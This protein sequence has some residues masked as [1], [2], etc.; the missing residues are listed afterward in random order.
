MFPYIC[1]LKYNIQWSAVT[2]LSNYIRHCNKSGRKW[3]RY[4]NY[5]RHPWWASCGATIVRIWEKTDRVTMALHYITILLCS[6]IT[7]CEFN[8]ILW[9]NIFRP[10][11][12]YLMK[13]T[14]LKSPASLNPWL[15]QQLSCQLPDLLMCVW[16]RPGMSGEGK[17]R[18]EWRLTGGLESLFIHLLT[19]VKFLWMEQEGWT[20]FNMNNCFLQIPRASWW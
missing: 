9:F 4:S 11:L 5:N 15:S 3:I 8:V 13:Y 18:L 20:Q 10:K 17:G 14:D 6:R 16:A 7:Q 1:I 2:M 12:W 19:H